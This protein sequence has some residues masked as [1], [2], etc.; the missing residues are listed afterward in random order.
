[1]ALGTATVCRFRHCWTAHRGLTD[2]RMT[3]MAELSA[4]PLL[5]PAVAAALLAAF[6]ERFGYDRMAS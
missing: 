6:G 2:V 1:M 5:M 3:C 4:A